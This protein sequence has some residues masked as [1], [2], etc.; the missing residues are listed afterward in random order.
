MG[1]LITLRCLPFP[2]LERRVVNWFGSLPLLYAF[3]PADFGSL[4][5]RISDGVVGNRGEPAFFLRKV[6]NVLINPIFQA[7]RKGPV[8]SRLGCELFLGLKKSWAA[9]VENLG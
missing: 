9:I 4:V 7:K 3:R 1:S 5:T 8:L 6:K 2:F